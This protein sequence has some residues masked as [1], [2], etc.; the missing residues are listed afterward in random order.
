MSTLFRRLGFAVALSIAPAAIAAQVA[1][2]HH[3][4]IR[5]TVTSDSGRALPGAEVIV[6]R[7]PDRAY[8]SANTDSSGRYT[9]TWDHGTGDYLVHVSAVGFQA[10]RKRVTRA[11]ADSVFVVDVKL[12]PQL[13]VQQLETMV[14]RARN[15]KP[16]RGVPFGA[17]VGASEQIASGV[18]GALPPDLAG[19]LA[20]IASTIPGVMPTSGGISVLGLGPGQNS[21]TLNGMAFAGADIPRDANTRVRVSASSY[22]PSQ[23]WF[24]GARTNVELAP[25]NIFSSR[26]SHLTLDA[27]AF[28]YSDPISSRL[29]QR[30]TNAQASVGG[31]GELVDN[32]FYYNYGL[33]GSRRSADVASLVTADP[34]LL[35]HSGVAADSVAHFLQ[36]M[37]GAGIP[38]SAANVPSASINDNVSFIGRIDHAPFDAVSLTQAKNT[39]GITGYAKY[40]HAQALTMGP[41]S[42]PAHTGDSKQTIGSVQGEY[43]FY[44]GRDYLGD[45][46]SSVSYNRNQSNPYLQLPNGQVLV[47]SAFPGGTGGVSALQFGGNSALNSDTRN[48]TW[49]TTTDLQFYPQGLAAHRVKIDADARLDTYSQDVFGNQLGSFAYNSLA[50]L[51]ANQPASFSRTLNA[52]TRTGGEWNAFAALSDLWRVSQTLQVMYGARLEGNAFTDAPAYNPAV[53]SAFG[54]RTDYAPNSVHV[55]PRIGF[56]WIRSGQERNMMMMNSFGRF[57]GGPSGVLRGGFGEFRNMIAP[58]LLSTASVSTGLPGGVERLSCIGAAVPTPDWNAY[59]N[60][61]AAIPQQCAGSAGSSFADAAPNV[62][63]FDPAYTATRSWRGNLSW[64]STWHKLTYSLEGIYSLN[65]DQPGT[66]DLNF[67][68]APRFVLPGEGRPMFTDPSSIVPSSGLVSPVDARVTNAFGHVVSNHSDLRS[69]SKQATITLTPD[70]SSFLSRWY[71]SFGYTLSSIRAQQRGFDGSTFAN[72]NDRT[73]ARGDL[74]ARHQFLLQLGYGVKG[75][76]LSLMGRLQSGTPFTPMIGSDVNGDGLANDRAFIFDPNTVADTGLANGLRRLEG[77]SAANV[78]DCLASQTGSAAGRN[79]CQ[80]PWTTALN[81]RLGL[82]GQLLHL[83]RRVNVGINL[84]NP[85]GGL[86]QLLH[87]SN[88][89]HGWGTP[90]MPDAVLYTVRGYDPASSQFRYQVNPRFGST[91]PAL[92]TVRAP[93]R[94]TLDVSI[95]IGRP[96][97]EQQLDKWLNPG[98]DGHRGQKLTANDLKRRY[99]R[100]VP[101]PYTGVLQ[102]SDSLLLTRDQ[103]DELRASQL[104]YRQRMDSLWTDLAQYLADLPDHYDAAQALKRA[105]D[106]TDAAWEITRL[107]VQKTFK[108]VLSPV[109][110]QLLPGIASMLYNAKEPLHIRMFIATAGG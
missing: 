12:A 60:N 6:T 2:T 51:A 45:V 10:Y 47:S 22:D 50:D 100:D 49:E 110:L 97:D 81:A 108:G 24:S 20:S 13:K 15:P 63:L 71:F 80:G 74:D 106:A 23:G 27:P 58:S 30:F 39:W 98:R 62:Q 16:T 9:I 4:V 105:S 102:Q 69:V 67:T 18:D 86:D 26:R 75:V 66:V 44:F 11:G 88:N 37:Q 72:P 109:Q 83:G 87:G 25:G 8:K 40:A 77:S 48:L 7:A 103:V 64:S 55:S 65:L 96:I 29:G 28:Q 19:D 21:T 94:L 32:T 95:D 101:D 76:S 42:T 57:L 38:V 3:D 78:R 79:S 53:A 70:L 73:W 68:G 104:K 56:T 5:G 99:E 46:R 34:D 90:A 1:A 35:A 41:T 17:G 84:A 89:L 107:D 43:S 33:Q 61:P 82:T 91:N 31:D 52:P 36:L 14:S 85:L 92:N 54:A 93:F 59:D